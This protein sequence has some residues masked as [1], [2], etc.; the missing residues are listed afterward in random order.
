MYYLSVIETEWVTAQCYVRDVTWKTN[1]YD[2]YVKNYTDVIFSPPPTH[3]S[4]D[5]NDTEPGE[6]DTITTPVSSP[7]S[8]SSPSPPSP[9]LLQVKG[10]Y[11]AVEVK[12]K[13]MYFKSIVRDPS[14][15]EAIPPLYEEKNVYDCLC[16]VERLRSEIAFQRDLYDKYV[17]YVKKQREIEG[18][19]EDGETNAGASLSDYVHYVYDD[20]ED[21][22]FFVVATTWPKID[23]FAD[24]HETE[25]RIKIALV[26]ASLGMLLISTIMLKFFYS[27]Y[28]KE[29]K[30][31]EMYEVHGE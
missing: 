1:L 9:V 18:G 19:E 28:V 5:Q 8:S 11:Y 21:E 10:W 26:A 25:K 2:V 7:P 31:P 24:N 17:A 30:D 22:I 23:A 6:N 4:T 29:D 20:D 3:P 15:T 16:M 14:E 27:H 13:N 12:Y